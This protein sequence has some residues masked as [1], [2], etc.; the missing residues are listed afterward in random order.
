MDLFRKINITQINQTNDVDNK[1][2]NISEFVKKIDYNAEIT[3]IET[4][5]PSI[6]GLATN[7]ALTAAENKIPDISNLVKKT[8]YDAKLLDIESKYITQL[9]IIN[10][11]KTFVI[12]R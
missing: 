8:D 5:I 2:P 11:L 10:L 3:E 9:I 1:I 4:T 7:V 12:I 6:S